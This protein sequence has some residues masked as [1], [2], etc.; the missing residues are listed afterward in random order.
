MYIHSFVFQGSSWN[1]YVCELISRKIP[2]IYELR[3]G[4]QKLLLRVPSGKMLPT[5]RAR[6]FFL[7]C[8]LSLK[9]LS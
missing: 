4:N 5:L 9:Q 1:D 2:A 8:S 6:A 3:S 7:G